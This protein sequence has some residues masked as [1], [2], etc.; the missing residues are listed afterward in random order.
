[1]YK[2]ERGGRK[3]IYEYAQVLIKQQTMCSVCQK[4]NVL[5]LELSVWPSK[6]NMYTLLPTNK[7]VEHSGRD[8]VKGKTY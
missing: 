4:K 6:N 7:A 8:E 5:Y 1:M 2:D 3:V